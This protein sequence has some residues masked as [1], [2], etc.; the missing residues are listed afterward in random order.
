MMTPKFTVGDR[1]RVK[2]FRTVAK[3][4]KVDKRLN[5][6]LSILLDREISWLSWWDPKD[7]VHAAPPKEAPRA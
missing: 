2:G 3:V 7:L 5:K 6:G 1:V 4:Q